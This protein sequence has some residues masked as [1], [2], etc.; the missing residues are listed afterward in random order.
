M[1]FNKPIRKHR[2]MDNFEVLSAFRTFQHMLGYV[3]IH[4]RFRG[5]CI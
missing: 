5:K 2:L 4:F 3:R 1:G